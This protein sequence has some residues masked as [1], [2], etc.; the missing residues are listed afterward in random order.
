MG[1]HKSSHKCRCN[2]ESDK[3]HNGDKFIRDN[4]DWQN[5]DMIVVENFPCD[6][7]NQLHTRERFHMELL[8]ATLNIIPT[9]TQKE[10]Q[11]KMQNI[12][13][14]IKKNIIK[15]NQNM[16]KRKKKPIDKIMQT[17]SKHKKIL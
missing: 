6:S 14:N 12:S 1:R 16:S 15:E 9:K 7:K 8:H 11:Q 17:T 4:G 13:K 5:W 3:C 2:N 10:Y